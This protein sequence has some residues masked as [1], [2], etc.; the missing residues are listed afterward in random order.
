[1]QLM[2]VQPR[3]QALRGQLNCSQRTIQG[4]RLILMRQAIA[5]GTSAWTPALQ[6]HSITCPLQ[7]CTFVF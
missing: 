3:L 4:D 2:L 1:M 6:Q 7:R 5:C